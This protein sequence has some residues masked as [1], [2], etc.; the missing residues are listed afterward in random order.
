MKDTDTLR[1]TIQLLSDALAG[2]RGIAWM[3]LSYGSFAVLLLAYVSIQVYTS[4]LMEDVSQRKREARDITE[5]IGL[6]TLSYTALTSKSRISEHCEERLG[7]RVAD[8]EA[9]RRI[10][11]N[12]KNHFQM[13]PVEFSEQP[14]Q[15]RTVLGSDVSGITEV[16]RK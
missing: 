10:S 9:L 14:I 5:E 12:S 4:S 13:E 1:R 16:M 11:V 2:R 6:L 15:M 8:A 7:M 3:V